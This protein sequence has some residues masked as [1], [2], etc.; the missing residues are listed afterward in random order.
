MK[1]KFTNLK[2]LIRLTILVMLPFIIFTIIEI[3]PILIGC[4]NEDDG[5]N[6]IDKQTIDPVHQEEQ[7]VDYAESLK[8]VVKKFLED[9]RNDSLEIKKKALKD[10]LPVKSD[11][12]ILFPQ[13]AEMLWSKLE[14][15]LQDMMLYVDEV[16]N[17][18][19]KDEWIEIETIDVRKKDG[20]K[21]FVDVLKMLPRDI[22]VFRVVERSKKGTAAGSSSYLYVNDRWIFLR[23][24]D[25][26]PEV[27]ESNS[28]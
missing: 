2:I 17:E 28:N 11:L 7:V 25:M 4:K 21:R 14:P 9:M 5:T 12:Q 20:S 26:I 3:L 23:G 22:P 15:I 10:I 13:Y 18:L 16:S 8:N 1:K 24:L 6:N 19:T 27:I